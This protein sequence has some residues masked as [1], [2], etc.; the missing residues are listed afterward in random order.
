ME[1]VEQ[2]E[3][4]GDGSGKGKGNHDGNDQDLEKFILTDEQFVS[5]LDRRDD[6]AM[7]HPNA[8][9][10]G[11]ANGSEKRNKIEKSNKIAVEVRT[12]CESA[13]PQHLA[14]RFI[15]CEANIDGT[16]TIRR[17]RSEWYLWN[18][19][20]GCYRLAENDE[21][22]SLVRTW[23][24]T[25]DVLTVVGNEGGT[26]IYEWVPLKV[27]R[28][29]V[30]EV[31]DAFIVDGLMVGG[32]D[33]CWIE[34]IEDAPE[35]DVSKLIVSRNKIYDLVSGEC[36]ESTPSFFATSSLGTTIED[37]TDRPVEWLLFLERLWPDDPDSIHLLQEWFGYLLTADTRLH[38]ALMIIGPKRGGKGTI[39]RIARAMLGNHSVAG[40]TLG[41]LAG[42]F[43]LQPLLGK[44]LAIVSDARFTGGRDQAVVIERLLSI[45]GEDAL[46]VDRKRITSVTTKL[47]CKFIILSN[48]LPNF[49]D[50]SGAI[51]SR[52]IQ[53][54]LR[55]SWI[56]REDLGLT[57]R[58][59]DELPQILQWS[60]TGW[61]RL[62]ERGYLVQPDS[63]LEAIEDLMRASSPISAWLEDCTET[64]EYEDSESTESLYMSWRQWCSIEG[65]DNVGTRST[66]AKKLR[67]AAPGLVKYRTMDRGQRQYRYRA[68]RVKNTDMSH[69]SSD[70]YLF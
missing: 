1:Q 61:R 22:A 13:Y 39:A 32:D 70:D 57:A 14:E 58:L 41:S 64:G 3:S 12:R 56:G 59:L 26:D 40:P 51:A 17:W 29:V 7:S 37:V 27:T 25:V 50:S 54:T 62:N 68:I 10:N 28:N 48:E 11:H 24:N 63:A 30:G 38:K 31:V 36:I 44:R 53:L 69:V 5:W 33:N 15:E 60:I 55:N 47:P 46:S 35:W 21:I 16:P 45:T 66:F 43:G 6:A 52:F 49:S 9:G 20:T 8:P 65:R 34:D 19:G 2:V 42:P 23:L 4:N 67:A 18:G